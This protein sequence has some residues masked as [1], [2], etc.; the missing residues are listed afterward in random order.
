MNTPT[1]PAPRGRGGLLNP[2]AASGL[3][4]AGSGPSLDP[5]LRQEVG[6][7]RQDLG[8]LT[9][10]VQQQVEAGALER[11][12]R[13]T[14]SAAQARLQADVQALTGAFGDYVA[15]D[16]RDKALALAQTRLIALEQDRVR[17]FGGHER[18]RRQV[19]GLLHGQDAGLVRPGTAHLAT[20]QAL[21]EAAGYWLAA[22]QVAV[23][24]WVGNDPVLAAQAL[25]EAQR[26]D[27]PRTA[28]FMALLAQRAGRESA[29]ATWLSRWLDQQQPEA[30]GREAVLLIEALAQGLFGPSALAASAEHLERWARA[31]AALPG[32]EDRLAQ[33]WAR[34]LQA[35]AQAPEELLQPAHQALARVCPRWP[36]LQQALADAALHQVALR[37]IE[38]IADRVPVPVADLQAGIDELLET[39]VQRLA[40]EELPM[41][42]EIAW[43][44]RVVDCEG[45]EARAQARAP[46]EDAALQPR[47]RFEQWMLDV[48]LHPQRVAASPAAQALMLALAR[49]PLARAHAGWTAAARARVPQRL[50][51]CIGDWQGEL[52][53]GG[54]PTLEAE[55]L[56][57]DLLAHLDARQSGELAQLGE[58]WAPVLAG[59][60]AIVTLALTLRAG[61][62]P[63]WWPGLVL[64]GLLA[65]LG[66]GL[67]WRR[68]RRV[69]QVRA[70]LR[71]QHGAALAQLDDAL[72]AWQD[73]QSMLQARESVAPTV[74]ARLRALRPGTRPSPARRATVGAMPAE[75]P[76][77]PGS[78][79]L[80]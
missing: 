51:L 60:G 54:T 32:F 18:V 5:A 11:Q 9:R 57:E 17:R 56:R 4:E 75:V 77:V 28:L 62:Q 52:S 1:W 40:D 48:V 14:Q 45:D 12:E 19:L 73:V 33:G 24:A 27:A 25:A 46:D 43:Q 76:G 59:A 44:Q 66:G 55:R 3:P 2:P 64:A 21:L 20:E 22:A 70:T 69:A 63:A 36:E 38:C 8:N 72:D 47:V 78:G 31:T 80:R 74:L 67:F 23:A 29:S 16:R 35:Q 42:R 58:P 41:R 30:L 34:G 65:A 26:L 10:L 7:L 68:T 39:L 13:Q 15:R 53:A 37:D 6:Q 49:E 61:V 79:D 50:P 71:Q